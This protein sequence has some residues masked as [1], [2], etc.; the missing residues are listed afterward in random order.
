MPH[1]MSV[2]KVTFLFLREGVT[3]PM[4]ANDMVEILRV[5][6]LKFRSFRGLRL[7][8]PHQGQLGALKRRPNPK[9]LEKKSTSP[10]PLTRILDPL[11]SSDS[12]SNIANTA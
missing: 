11:L 12:R 7:L 9:P 3:S 5:K 2:D 4:R 1:L 8:G 6:S 10:P